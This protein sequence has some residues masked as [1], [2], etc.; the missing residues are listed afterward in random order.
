[1][2]VNLIAGGHNKPATFEG[3]A[4]S[5]RVNRT[6]RKSEDMAT[7]PGSSHGQPYVDV[8]GGPEPGRSSGTHACDIGLHVLGVVLELGNWE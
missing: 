3:G 5:F 2:A 4:V 8:G 7:L 1:M 6:C